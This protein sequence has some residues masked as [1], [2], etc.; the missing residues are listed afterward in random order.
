M[1]I[2]F[3]LVDK[4]FLKKKKVPD[5][6]RELWVME[7]VQWRKCLQHKNEDQSVDPPDS[8]KWWA[9]MAAASNP[10]TQ[11]RVTGDLRTNWLPR[12]ATIGKFRVLWETL[13]QKWK[14]MRKTP[15]ISFGSLYVHPLTCKHTYKHT[16]VI[17]KKGGYITKYFKVGIIKLVF[18]EGF[19]YPLQSF[20]L[21]HI[22]IHILWQDLN[23]I[24]VSISS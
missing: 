4:Q 16:K 10:S 2:K 18:I 20:K 24:I 19:I 7:L 3:H 8:Q 22:E 21:N 5:F 6:K 15:T 14:V 12:G 13:P 9:G 11:E 17:F 23:I 1:D